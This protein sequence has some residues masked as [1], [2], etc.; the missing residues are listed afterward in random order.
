M[1]FNRPSLE[2]HK[3]YTV[4]VRHAFAADDSNPRDIC[5]PNDQRDFWK[6]DCQVFDPPQIPEETQ[7]K[8]VGKENHQ[9][10]SC[11]P[12]NKTQRRIS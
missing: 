4:V 9:S 7:R 5:R 10:F 3:G 12:E 11:E 1:H 6:L 2:K 8:V